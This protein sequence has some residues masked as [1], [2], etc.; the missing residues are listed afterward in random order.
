MF[1]SL[2]I[3][4]SYKREDLVDSEFESII[5][6]GEIEELKEKAAETVEIFG[7]ALKDLSKISPK[8]VLGLGIIDEYSDN[9]GAEKQADDS[10][11]E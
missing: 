7:T 3:G 4:V 9:K 11:I 1:M 6:E 10:S 8:L 5:I 2:S